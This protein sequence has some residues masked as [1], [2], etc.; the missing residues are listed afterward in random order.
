MI[1]LLLASNL[2]IVVTGVRV[3]EFETKPGRKI[4]GRDVRDDEFETVPEPSKL[5]GQDVHES[6]SKPP[7][8]LARTLT[9]FHEKLSDLEA[10]LFLAAKD[11]QETRTE[12]ANTKDELAETKDELSSLRKKVSSRD[13]DRLLGARAGHSDVR[14]FFPSF[15]PAMNQVQG[16]TVP[17]NPGASGAG[18]DSGNGRSPLLVQML[19]SN[20]RDTES[21]EVLRESILMSNLDSAQG[22]GDYKSSLTPFCQAPNSSSSVLDAQ[23]HTSN[24]GRVGCN[25][26]HRLA[27]K[28]KSLQLFDLDLNLG[29][30]AHE[31]GMSGMPGMAGDIMDIVSQIEK[32]PA[33]W[34]SNLLAKVAEPG[35]AML[36]KVSRLLAQSSLQVATKAVEAQCE[37][38]KK[39][40][41]VSK[42]ASFIQNPAMSLFTQSVAKY[43]CFSL[44]RS[45]DVSFSIPFIGAQLALMPPMLT[46]VIEVCV[47]KT[48]ASPWH[49]IGYL[50]FSL[51]GFGIEVM[52]YNIPLV[53]DLDDINQDVNADGT[54]KHP[55]RRSTEK[56]QCP[57]LQETVAEGKERIKKDGSLKLS[58]VSISQET[59]VRYVQRSSG[60]DAHDWLDVLLS[61]VVRNRDSLL[62]DN[63]NSGNI[64]AVTLWDLS[65][66]HNEYLKVQITGL[67]FKGVITLRVE[68][69]SGLDASST[70]FDNGVDLP[71][72]DLNRD[73][74]TLMDGMQCFSKCFKPIVADAMQK[75]F[76]TGFPEAKFRMGAGPRGDGQLAPR[77]DGQ[78]G[79]M[80][81]R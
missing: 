41:M 38:V 19:S 12:L 23:G 40:M 79:P 57:D 18:L 24:F 32:N 7:H 47:A 5:G 1:R 3:D 70:L 54:L 77:G 76:S 80:T 44:S 49:E 78:T 66:S 39:A 21:W 25:V 10:S 20:S 33:R 22:S 28:G 36:A 64:D 59:G 29:K 45:Q 26:S 43:S 61:G 46:V 37:K 71:L 68:A 42:T 58:K 81:S 27:P 9:F 17:S 51:L 4:S 62:E 11:L 50:T 30:H 2:F 34:A 6:P 72:I 73:L 14:D 60:K 74:Y 75:A 65:I 16:G 31:W 55:T 48:I 35:G 56:K 67:I 13:E 8:A 63:T 15:T 69:S 53:N 52:N